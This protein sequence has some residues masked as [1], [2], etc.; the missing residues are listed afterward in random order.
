ML[1]LYLLLG[2]VQGSGSLFFCLFTFDPHKPFQHFRSCLSSAQ[3]PPSVPI[4]LS[5]LS[6]SYR[7]PP[8]GVLP[9]G[10]PHFLS[11]CPSLIRLSVPLS[12]CPAVN[13]LS[14]LLSWEPYT[15]VPSIPGTSFLMSFRPW[16]R[17][18]PLSP[19]GCQLLPGGERETGI[20]AQSCN[21]TA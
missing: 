20:D 15:I 4:F 5:N 11:F 13:V 14:L 18:H 16:L 9:W 6:R 7:V 19:T 10:P 1:L 21:A 17:S 3:S 2:S 8:W 12:S